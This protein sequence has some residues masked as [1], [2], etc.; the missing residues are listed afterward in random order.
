M[1]WAPKA[2]RMAL[3]FFLAC[4]V[5]EMNRLKSFPA[6][7]SGRLLKKARQFSFG[8]NGLEKQVKSTLLFLDR[9][10]YVFRPRG[11][12]GLILFFGIIRSPSLQSQ[13]WRGNRFA[14]PL[15]SVAR[16]PSGLPASPSRPG[17]AIK[18]AYP[19]G[20]PDD[21][22]PAAGHGV[23]HSIVSHLFI[24]GRIQSGISSSI[25]R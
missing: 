3:F 20:S 9:R 23:Y 17:P 22:F 13:F 14:F 8:V 12:R 2:K 24:K 15:P 4:F 10:E 5:S 11:E 18:G 6:K 1:T 21:W 7:V 16:T 25:E 19:L